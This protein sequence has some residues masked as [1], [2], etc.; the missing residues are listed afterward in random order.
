VNLS[1]PYIN[2]KDISTAYLKSFEM[3]VNGNHVYA[4][5]TRISEPILNDI[6]KVVDTIQGMDL[7]GLN[8]DNKIHESFK[9]F[10]VS[11]EKA[12]VWYGRDWIVDRVNVLLKPGG[13]YFKGLEREI[14]V[15]GQHMKQIDFIK[16]GLTKLCKKKQR[17]SSAYGWKDNTFSCLVFCPSED[18]YPFDTRTRGGR[19]PRCLLTLDFKP[20][21]RKLHLIATWRAQF[22]NTKAYGNFISLAM[23]LREICKYTGF[24]PGSLISIANKAILKPGVKNMQLLKRLQRAPSPTYY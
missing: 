14:D 6:D 11:K 21:G 2:E 8:L 13:D 22:F 18:Y 12:K 24:Q 9:E 4:L 20:E 15:N 3:V 23:L 17:L 16:D 19:T 5:V 1:L 7:V 10:P